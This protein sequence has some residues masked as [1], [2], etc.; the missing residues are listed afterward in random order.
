MK[1]FAA[2]TKKGPDPV[3]AISSGLSLFKDF[4]SL[5]KESNASMTSDIKQGVGFSEISNIM[6][7]RNMSVNIS[8]IPHIMNDFANDMQRKH[9]EI[10][11]LLKDRL[12]RELSDVFVGMP[13]QLIPSR[14]MG[15]LTFGLG[16]CG[17]D[18]ML[19][20]AHTSFTPDPTEP[21]IA[22][23]RYIRLKSSFTP[24]RPYVILTESESNFFRSSC[25]SKIV[26]MPATITIDHITSVIQLNIDLYRSIFKF[27]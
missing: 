7:V 20:L 17:G 23:Y 13:T 22:N 9:G 14:P 2:D 24:S 25:E 4:A 27:F 6:H 21:T 18:G 26:Y 19:D 15:L 1:C 16:F 11:G 12:D 10:N 8:E 3:Q 5:F